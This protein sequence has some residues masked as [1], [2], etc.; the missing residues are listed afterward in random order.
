MQDQRIESGIVGHNSE[1]RTRKL[2]RQAT[3][4]EGNVKIQRVRSRTGNPD[5]LDIGPERL[6]G[7]YE[8][9]QQLRLVGSQK[10]FDI[11]VPR[12]EFTNRLALHVLKID[13]IEMHGLGLSD[14]G[15]QRVPASRSTE[16]DC[17]GALKP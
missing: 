6:Q 9:D 10:Y 7:F 16:A 11:A 3:D 5:V 4:V 17:F 12:P 8:I 1:I 2:Q 13:Q 15:H 14:A